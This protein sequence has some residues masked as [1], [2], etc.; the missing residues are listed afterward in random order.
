[1]YFTK[2][3]EKTNKQKLK[4]QKDSEEIAARNQ[5]LN[6]SKAMTGLRSIGKT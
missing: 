5:G 4:Q 3:K 2:V 1:M 6:L